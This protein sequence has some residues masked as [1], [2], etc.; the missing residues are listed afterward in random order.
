[1]FSAWFPPETSKLVNAQTNKI[2][3][4]IKQR[5]R[6]SCF[7]SLFFHQ[8]YWLLES[9]II[10]TINEK[11][12]ILFV[13]SNIFQDW[14]QCIDLTN[15]TPGIKRLGHTALDDKHLKMIVRKRK[16]DKDGKNT[17]PKV[18]QYQ[19]YFHHWHGSIEKLS[20]FFKSYKDR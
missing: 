4:L 2:R 14:S 11:A 19:S 10:A 16:R 15:G 5:E 9:R 8:K 3:C 17:Q 1:M 18:S 12:S 6:E 20:Y 7:A 13:Y